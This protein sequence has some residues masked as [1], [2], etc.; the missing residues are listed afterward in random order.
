MKSALWKCTRCGA[1][2]HVVFGD[3][4]QVARE[5]AREV[6]RRGALRRRT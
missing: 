2:F 1:H 4:D 3:L 6:Q 5:H